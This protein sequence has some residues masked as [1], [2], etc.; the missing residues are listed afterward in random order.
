MSGIHRGNGLLQVA[1][2]EV[3]I[4]TQEKLADDWHGGVLS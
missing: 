2:V 3:R 1:V 4:D